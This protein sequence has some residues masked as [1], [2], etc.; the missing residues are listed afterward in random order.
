MSFFVGFSAIA[1]NNLNDY[2]VMAAK[3][4]PDVNVAFN[5]YLAA[6][7]KVPQVGSLP[8]PQASAGFFLQPMELI[9][10]NQVANIQVMQ[11][12]PWFGTL[13]AS[14][15]EAAL[16]AKASYEKFNSA[17]S[18]VFYQ[19]KSNW[20]QLQ[21]TDEEI[22]LI[23]ENIE[24]L[25]S[26]EKLVLV[27][28]QSP[29]SESSAPAMPSTKNSMN[30]SS[31]GMSGSMG[32]NKNQTSVA[33]IATR[34]SSA[35]MSSGMSSSKS[36][37]Q[38]VLRVKM[39]ILEQQ[40][41]LAELVDQ[42]E[43]QEV[44]FNALLNRDLTIPIE[45]TAKLE[46]EMLPMDKAV[47]TDSILSNN[48]MLAML[49]NE[50]ESYTA[51]QEKAKKMGLPMLGLGLNYMVIQP[52]AGNT[53]MMNGNDMIM[54]MVSVSIPIYRKKYTAMQN[55]AKYMKEAINQQTISLR[56]DL[57]VQYQ[58]IMQQMDN[59]ARKVILY[60]EQENLARKTT[61]LLLSDFSTSGANYEE[62]LR[63]QLKVLDYGFNYIEAVVENNIAV[64]N[65]EMLLNYQKTH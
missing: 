64:A 7:E 53:A 2:M 20:Y 9:G 40:N 31:S 24:L 57:R 5:Q 39:E 22:E 45:I 3:Q 30:K 1:Q 14:K 15:S 55:E 37:L 44:S 11:M 33:P 65:I 4:N 43:T 28:F 49:Q 59:A 10:G 18:T 46:L 16:M 51:M 26:L 23:K 6:L 56:N 17:K 60:K 61:E 8:D 50:S 62:V 32:G 21:K 25:E 13:K 41:R 54:P 42:R 48:S 52:R 27:K 35:N 36:G 47:I 19:V 12:F 63:M 58:Q 29:V 38:D 34:S